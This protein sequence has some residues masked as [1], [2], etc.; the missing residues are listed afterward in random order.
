MK[1]TK[2]RWSQNSWNFFTGCTEVSPGCDHCY[3]RVIA[4][5]FRGAAFPNG[6]EPTFKSNK[7]RDPE[8]WKEPSRIFVN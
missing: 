3:A 5:R 4:E 8:K 7:L 1:N 6:F 2:I